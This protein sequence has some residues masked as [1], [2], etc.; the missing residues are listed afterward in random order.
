M[1]DNDQLCDG[2]YVGPILGIAGQVATQRINRQGEPVLHSLEAL[3]R[4]VKAGD[5][6]EIS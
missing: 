2:I 5:L 1:R 4:P 3:N 6:V